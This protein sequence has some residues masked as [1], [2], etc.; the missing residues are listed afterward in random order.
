MDGDVV[1][2]HN[3]KGDT[4]TI[5]EAI[6][7]VQGISSAGKGEGIAANGEEDDQIVETD[8]EQGEEDIGRDSCVDLTSNQDDFQLPKMPRDEKHGE[9]DVSD[10]RDELESLDG[11][12][13][14]EDGR[15]YV[16]PLTFMKKK[17]HEFNPNVDM[18][19][20]NFRVRMELSIYNVFREAV[21]AH[22]V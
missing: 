14:D 4:Q 22:A 13:D 7:D 8:Y 12:E 19:D 20:P 9:S 6:D 5:Y 2:D 10:N 1:D 17:Y 16:R 18:K 3:S 11:L 15:Q 21:R